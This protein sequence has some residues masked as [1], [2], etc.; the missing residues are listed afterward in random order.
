MKLRRELE[1]R[2]YDAVQNA[3]GRKE[4]PVQNLISFL[5]KSDQNEVLKTSCPS[6]IKTVR[7]DQLL[8]KFMYD[9]LTEG[10]EKFNQNMQGFISEH[11][12]LYGVESRTSCPL[13]VTR[14]D[15]SLQSLSHAGLYPCGEGAGYAGGITSAACDGIRCADKIFETLL[16]GG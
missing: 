7:L 12:T 3:K 9:K 2:A 13:R 4:L 11:A 10:I 8:P 5:K 15:Q 14:D 1:T 6:G 16:S